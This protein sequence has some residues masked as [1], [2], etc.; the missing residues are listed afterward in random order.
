MCWSDFKNPY[1]LLSTAFYCVTVISIAMYFGEIEAMFGKTIGGVL[2]TI[3]VLLSTLP[4]LFFIKKYTQKMDEMQHSVYFSAMIPGFVI[5][6]VFCLTYGLLEMFAGLP[7][8]N[9]MIYY[10]IFML[11][12]AVSSIVKQRQMS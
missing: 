3:V 1:Y 8:L 7:S 12:W 6:V 9:A 10:T 2:A 11:S 4:F 5:G